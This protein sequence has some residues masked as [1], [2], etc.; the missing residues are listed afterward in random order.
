M[1]FRWCR[2]MF[3]LAFL[4]ACPFPIVWF[5]A[6]AALICRNVD[7]GSFGWICL[8]FLPGSCRFVFHSIIGRDGRGRTVRGVLLLDDCLWLRVVLELM[9]PSDDCF[10]MFF[11]TTMHGLLCHGHG[12]QVGLPCGHEFQ[13][14]M[15]GQSHGGLRCVLVLRLHPRMHHPI[16]FATPCDVDLMTHGRVPWAR[17]LGIRVRRGIDTCARIHVE[18]DHGS[19]RPQTRPRGS[20]WTLGRDTCRVLVGRATWI[21]HPLL[22]RGDVLRNGATTAT[23]RNRK[24]ETRAGTPLFDFKHMEETCQ[25]RGAGDTMIGDTYQHDGK[26]WLNRRKR[27]VHACRCNGRTMEGPKKSSKVGEATK[28]T[29]L[30][31]SRT[32]HGSRSQL[33]LFKSM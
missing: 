26:R 25:D 20:T 22:T 30:L 27:C 13:A 23:G 32:T 14:P 2:R 31:C 7:A 9:R 8:S 11:S 33:E 5:L 17:A 1:L 24:M 28:G 3:C 29:C 6:V 10:P 18:R 19:Q 15:F 16:V 12:P 4:S 21:V